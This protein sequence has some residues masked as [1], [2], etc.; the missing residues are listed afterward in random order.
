[1]SSE[2]DDK[3]AREFG[4]RLLHWFDR[5][6]RRDLPWSQG[7]DP[8][9]IWI[10]EIMLQQTQVTT[11]IGYY[12]R[13]MARFPTVAEL[14]GADLDEVLHLWT[15][16]G[17]Y[18]RA[19]NLHRAARIIADDLEGCFPDDIEQLMAL[20]GIG[21]STAGAILAFA[22]RQ[23]HPILDGNVKRVLARVHR[24][25]GWPGKR[26]VEKRLWTLADSYTPE[27]RV[28][29]YTQAIMDLGAGV[30]LRRNPRCDTCPV[31]GFC[32]ALRHGDPECYPERAP[33]KARPL[34]STGMLFIRNER[35]EVLLQQ[36]PPTGIW[37][38]LW[39]LPECDAGLTAATRGFESLG[40]ILELGPPGEVIR[41]SFT[42]FDLDITPIPARVR[43][44]L[45]A[46]MD[47]EKLLWYN[48]GQPR[49]L[50]LAAP[51]KRL[52]ENS[53]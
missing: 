30:C 14:A 6:G 36:R 45:E 43:A 33:R 17:Y 3:H 34:R 2:A 4:E 41:H 9:R 11:V 19:R 7:K 8:Y 48:P 40:L 24:V 12:R 46:V 28:D 27:Q 25:S 15:G 13:F 22:H 44:P 10:S 29:D 39:G 35:G 16:L 1:L 38:G 52:I 32:E 18:A 20:P 26:E 50:G 49:A 42:H 51:V 23:R 31:A 21:R 5:H 47:N 53:S 37:G